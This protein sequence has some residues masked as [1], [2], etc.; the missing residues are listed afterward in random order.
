MRSAAVP[1]SRFAVFFG[2]ALALIQLCASSPVF[3]QQENSLTETTTEIEAASPE[4]RFRI[5]W[6]AGC[7][8]LR[9]HTYNRSNIA[10]ADSAAAADTVG[11]VIV[12]CD[13]RNRDEDGAM[14][15]IVFPVP[16]G[17]E[18]TPANIT[19]VIGEQLSRTGQ[20]IL[21][22]GPIERNGLTGVRVLARE[23]DSSR[24]TWIEG[25]LAKGRIVVALA[26]NSDESI[27]KNPEIERF[28]DTL[29]ILD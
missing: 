21:R 11:S 9:T 14:V 24:S 18:H 27:F 8:R 19:E 4:G 16:G 1:N 6:P 5:V 7:S 28:F 20:S 13:R 17:E 25:F 10:A 26:W 12:M 3:A 15:L 22:Q 29:E 2:V 23:K